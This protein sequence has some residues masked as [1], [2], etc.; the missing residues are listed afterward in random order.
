[1]AQLR[2]ALR[3]SKTREK[4]ERLPASHAVDGVAL[5][6]YLHYA[7]FYDKN[8]DHGQR[9]E[10]TCVLTDAPFCDHSTA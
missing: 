8:G 5:A 9:W 6:D 1:M 10:G 4:A 3:L 2:F 7:P